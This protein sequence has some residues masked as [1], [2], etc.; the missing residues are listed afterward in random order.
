MSC[1]NATQMAMKEEDAGRVFHLKVLRFENTEWVIG[2]VSN[3]QQ[4]WPS[5]EDVPKVLP[6][7]SRSE[8]LVRPRFGGWSC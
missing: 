6:A 4:R 8:S 5:T 3:D 7:L 2:P 1:V